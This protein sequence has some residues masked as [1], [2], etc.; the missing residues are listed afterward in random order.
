LRWLLP[1]HSLEVFLQIFPLS[2]LLV[3][4]ALFPI[5]LHLFLICLLLKLEIGGVAGVWVDTI[6]KER[7]VA[8][9]GETN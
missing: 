5:L 4:L 3:N 7:V 9:L 1:L 2:Y 6:A 8:M